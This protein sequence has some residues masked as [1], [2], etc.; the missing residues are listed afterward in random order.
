MRA[1]YPGEAIYRETYK[2]LWGVRDEFVEPLSSKEGVRRDFNSIFDAYHNSIG[3]LAGLRSPRSTQAV[4][5][6]L[7]DFRA[8]LQRNKHNFIDNMRTKGA[9]HKVWRLYMREILSF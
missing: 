3:L 6:S 4:N 7:S 1:K 9:L 2:Y 5:D 8:V